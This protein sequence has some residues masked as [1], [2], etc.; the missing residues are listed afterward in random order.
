[1]KGKGCSA[2]KG[3]L[4]IRTPGWGRWHCLVYR[5]IFLGLKHFLL[6]ERK[7]GC[8]RTSPICRNCIRSKILCR[9]YHKSLTWPRANDRKRAVL[10]VSRSLF[11]S[12]GI[13]TRLKFINTCSK[14][15]EMHR[16]LLDPGMHWFYTKTREFILKDPADLHIQLAQYIGTY[17]LPPTL[18]LSIHPRLEGSEAELIPYCKFS[19]VAAFT[20][21]TLIGQFSLVYCHS[22]PHSVLI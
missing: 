8:D 11:R 17:A 22:F 3:K 15:V 5:I 2:C 18:S 9:P 1:M 20:D 16:C 21:N 7:I 12:E 4:P 13:Y 10:G 14:D 19:R 6:T